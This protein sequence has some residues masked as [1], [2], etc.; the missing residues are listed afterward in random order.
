MVIDSR[1]FIKWGKY[2]LQMIALGADLNTFPL[3]SSNLH[4]YGID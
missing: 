3:V 4:C 1:N 2:G